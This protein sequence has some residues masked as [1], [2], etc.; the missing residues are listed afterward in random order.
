[1]KFIFD[2]HFPPCLVRF[3][4]ELRVNGDVQLGMIDDVEC[5][6]PLRERYKQPC[7]D[8]EWID[9]LKSS[10]Q[11][12]VVI[13]GDTM[14]WRNPAQRR[15]LIESGLTF[16]IL[17]KEFGSLDQ[18]EK[19]AK[20]LQIWK[21]LLNAVRNRPPGSIFIVSREWKLTQCHNPQ[22]IAA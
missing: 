4:D 2:N 12:W 11:Y 21:D 5:I 1:M 10:A 19:S 8:Q 13:S 3:L 9:G 6:V 14:L 16:V 22:V 18:Y 17:N 15:G 7:A 20:V